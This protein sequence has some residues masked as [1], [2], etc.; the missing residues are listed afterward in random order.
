MSMGRDCKFQSF[1]SKVK[2]PE[3][4]VPVPSVLAIGVPWDSF[5]QKN[6]GTAWSLM[7]QSRD[8]GLFQ[9]DIIIKNAYSK[10]YGF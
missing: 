2:I 10:I 5:S 3:I 7:G 8:F 1:F 9:N 6:R 4:I